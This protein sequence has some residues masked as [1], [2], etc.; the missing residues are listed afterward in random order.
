MERLPVWED[1]ASVAGG[2][3]YE[4]NA[5]SGRLR[6]LLVCTHMRQQLADAER[7]A[8]AQA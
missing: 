5:R 6:P 4:R 3:R 1:A 7:H 8:C 2:T